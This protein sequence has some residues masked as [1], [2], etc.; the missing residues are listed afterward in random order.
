[1]EDVINILNIFGLYSKMSYD[2]SLL[3]AAKTW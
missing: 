3:E 2:N 1:M